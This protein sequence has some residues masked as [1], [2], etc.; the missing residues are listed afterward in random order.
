MGLLDR[1]FFDRYSSNVQ[2]AVWIVL[3]VAVVAFFNVIDGGNARPTTAAEACRR[4]VL[5]DTGAYGDCMDS[6]AN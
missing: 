5:E 3:I 2:I 4:V 6:W 1:Y